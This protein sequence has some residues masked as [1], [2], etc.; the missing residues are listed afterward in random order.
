MHLSTTLQEVR[1]A[2]VSPWLDSRSAIKKQP[3]AHCQVNS[4]GIIG[5][6]QAE[7]FHG[8]EDRALLQF[9]SAHYQALAQHFPESAHL[10]IPGS[11]GENLVATGMSEANLC[12]GDIVNIGSAVLQVTQ[13]RKPCYKL[14]FVFEQPT[15]SKFVQDHGMAGWFYRV[16][17]PG[18]IS[19]GDVMTVTER[20]EPEWPLSKVQHYLNI[21]LLNEDA[22]KQLLTLE[23]LAENIK[24]TFQKRLENGKAEDWDRRLYKGGVV[25][26]ELRV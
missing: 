7:V 15:I 9:D 26:L 5:D 1:L 20:P 25:P 12:I 13:P 21:E 22:M 4:L 8:G 23:S 10:F 6:E 16:L 3:V 24:G 19:A 17:V 14:N 11:F 18:T 2:K